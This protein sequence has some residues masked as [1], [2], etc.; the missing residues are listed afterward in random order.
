MRVR[1]LLVFIVSFTMVHSQ[2]SGN[3]IRQY[4]LPNHSKE[5]SFTISQTG[6]KYIYGDCYRYFK[7]QLSQGRYTIA[8]KCP[9]TTSETKGGDFLIIDGTLYSDKRNEVIDT[10][11]D[12]CVKYTITTYHMSD[13]QMDKKECTH[14]KNAIAK[15]VSVKTLKE[16]EKQEHYLDVEQEEQDSK[17]AQVERDREIAPEHFFLNEWFLMIWQSLFGKKTN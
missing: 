2:P 13:S 3:E 11:E 9:S 10:S 4:T 1:V 17:V 15:G 6:D 7:I 14:I 5:I 12:Q 16:M 8:Y